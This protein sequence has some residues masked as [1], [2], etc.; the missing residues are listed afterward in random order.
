MSRK[1]TIALS[2]LIITLLSPLAP[3]SFFRPVASVTAN[4]APFQRFTSTAEPG[5]QPRILQAQDGKVWVFWT[6]PDPGNVYPHIHYEI[7][8]WTSWSAD[9][10][11]VSSGG[12]FQDVAPTVVQLANH[13]IILAFSSNR[14]GSNYNLY[15]KTYSAGTGW[16][17]DARFTNGTNDEFVSSLVPANDGSLWLFWD[18]RYLSAPP[19][20]GTSFC[21]WIYSKIY[22]AGN[23]WSPETAVATNVVQ[24]MQPSAFQMQDGRI[25]LSYARAVDA[26][27][28]MIH[29]YYNIYN[30]A[31]WA[32][33]T[34]LTSSTNVDRHPSILQ[35]TNGTIWVTWQ[36]R[37]PVAG[38][39]PTTPCFQ[40]DIFYITSSNNGASWSPENQITNDGNNPLDDTQPSAAEMKDHRIW[41]FWSSGRDPEGFLNIYYSTSNLI[42]AHDVAVTSLAVAPIFIRPGTPVSV[43]ATVQNVGNYTETFYT[44]LSVYNVTVAY[45]G[46]QSVSL[47]PGVSKLVRFTWNTLG[48]NP[49]KYTV[50]YTIPGI[51]GQPS[52]FQSHNVILGKVHVVAPG[53]L[54]MTGRVDIGDAAIV[55][56]AFGSRGPDP[57]WNAKADINRDGHVDIADAAILA[58]AFGTKPGDPKW[59]PLADLDGN[60]R[61][62]IVDAALLAFAFGTTG[63]SPNWN[64]IADLVGHNKVDIGD[65]AIVAFWF[66]FSC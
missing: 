20:S 63:P 15:L 59:N 1:I 39:S 56:F 33:E 18:R 34:P 30:G 27:L 42:P 45:A 21:T 9:Q 7:Y 24:N 16:S 48:I 47:A 25:W 22:R 49:G 5:Q 31:S 32:G 40:S 23:G 26:Q 53:D 60:G 14:A 10:V 13:T 11:L 62:D 19:C 6:V 44:Y 46:G 50:N 38:C 28:T 65:A 3:L 17:P 51:P 41:V 61:V 66:G 58:D 55:A 4:W 57:N 35:D 2:L 29:I 43:N 37:L 36:R 8:N 12:T 64:P 54:F 52:N